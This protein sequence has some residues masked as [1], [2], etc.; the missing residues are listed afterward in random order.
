[1]KGFVYVVEVSFAIFIFAFSIWSSVSAIDIKLH[2][3]I[4]ELTSTAQAFSNILNFYD[5]NTLINDTVFFVNITDYII[6][7][8]MYWGIYIE[9]VPKPLIEIGCVNCTGRQVLFLR[10]ILT[11]VYYNNRFVNFSV[12]FANFTSLDKVLKFDTLIF[13]NFT[14]FD[15][16][17]LIQEYLRRGGKIMAITD[18]T[19]TDFGNM[20]NTF[21]LSHSGIST[22]ISHSEFSEYLDSPPYIQ[23]YFIGTGFRVEA[24]NSVD[25]KKQGIWKIWLN[26][27]EVNITNTLNVEIEGVGT[28]SEGDVFVL[29]AGTE[30]SNLPNIDYYFRIKKVFPEEVYIQPLNTSFVFPQSIESNEVKVK[31][32]N[33]KNVL[34][35]KQGNE[36]YSSVVVNTTTS[37]AAWISYFPESSEFELLLKSTILAINNKF[38]LKEF[39]GKTGIAMPFYASTCCDIPELLRITLHLG[40]KY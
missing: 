37:R 8:N 40:Y 23:K 38:T 21:S 25:S 1:M 24:K 12:S 15:N 34:I 16:N 4:H 9:G 11:P 29:N 27:K 18:I 26:E 31:T 14:D 10:N 7:D 3:D 20:D 30:N 13:I 19:N 17:E 2:R 22:D 6:P 32:E 35:S 28:L 39:Y 33:G 5:I 36:I